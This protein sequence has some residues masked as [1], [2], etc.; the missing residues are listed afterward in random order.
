MVRAL[1][2]LGDIS[3]ASFD[4]SLKGFNPDIRVIL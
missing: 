4:R 1:K 2:I 3:L